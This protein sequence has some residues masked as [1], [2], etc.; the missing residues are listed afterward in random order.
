MCKKCQKAIREDTP[1]IGMY[2]QSRFFDGATPMWYHADC[3]LNA[4]VGKKLLDIV[5]FLW[6]V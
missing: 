2:V 4:H 3:S 5:R 6:L 1:R